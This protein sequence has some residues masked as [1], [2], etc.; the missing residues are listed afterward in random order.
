MACCCVFS[1]K[2][3]LLM[4]CRIQ[5]VGKKITS[6]RNKEMQT[7]SGQDDGAVF[8][9]HS[10]KLLSSNLP[11]SCDLSVWS[12]HVL[13][14]CVGSL[15]VLCLPPTVHMHSLHGHQF[16]LVLYM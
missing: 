14:L 6:K 4:Q 7:V 1:Y 12:L 15:W 13:P 2:A 11:A 8:S 16:N 3:S 10:R 9:C 5:K